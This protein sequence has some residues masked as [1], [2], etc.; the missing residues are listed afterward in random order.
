MTR[1]GSAYLSLQLQLPGFDRANWPQRLCLQDHSGYGLVHVGRLR[2][3]G[4]EGVQAIMPSKPRLAKLIYGMLA[5]KAARTRRAAFCGGCLTMTYFRTGSP[6][7]HR[8]AAVSRSCSG[9]EGVVPTGCGR[10]ALEVGR[11]KAR[12]DCFGANTSAQCAW[13]WD[14]AARAISIG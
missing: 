5:K 13:L 7:Y 8:R 4:E 9:W 3:W 12:S 2:I 11:S 6:Y 14:Q 1:Q 10:Q